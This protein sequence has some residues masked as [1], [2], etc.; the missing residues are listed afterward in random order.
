MKKRSKK[1]SVSNTASA[2]SIR[3]VADGMKQLE[4]KLAQ[5]RS[6]PRKRGAVDLQSVIEYVQSDAVRRITPFW[7]NA[8]LYVQREVLRE[9][10]TIQAQQQSIRL[11]RDS[12]VVFV[13]DAP[14]L[15]WG[16]P[17]RY[18]LYDARSNELY[19]QV[20]AAFPP[21]LVDT[22]E[23][24]QLYH[25]QVSI[26][27]S[28]LV[29]QV[30]PDRIPLFPLSRSQRYALLFSGASNNRHT[31]DLEFLFR[32]L[33][34][35]YGYDKNN[36]YVLNYDGTLNYNGDPQPASKWPGDNTN[37]RMH[38]DGE[39]TK[40]EFENA[41]D[42]LKSRLKGDD[43]LLIHTNNHGWYDDSGSFMSTYSGA[44]YYASELGDKLAT[45]PKFGCLIVMMEQ[46]ASGGFSQT[47]LD[48]SPAARTS[49]A[50]AC[51]PTVSSYG[52]SDF[53]FFAR[54][55]IA[56]M[57]GAD[58][59]GANLSSN[60]DT[61]QDGYISAQE[62]FNYANSVANASDS[63]NF[64]EKNDGGSCRLTATTG[65]RPWWMD[66]LLRA[67]D[68]FWR[69]PGP[70]PGPDVYRQIHEELMPRVENATRKFSKRAEALDREVSAQLKEIVSQVMR[71]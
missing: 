38:V 43:S 46:C 27:H 54:D 21:H 47:I 44:A 56:G 33:V 51:G 66:G 12:I 15:N 3:S 34:D 11:K 58:P 24:F 35:C 52:G 7:K 25:Q 17:C 40:A 59:Y 16:H 14:Q 8:N 37:Y 18:L 30:R 4:K 9:G 19:E 48:K 70:D 41:L 53:D 55:W 61:N 71:H 32:T 6:T 23:A 62:A 39:G 10:H 49:F 5:L 2:Q 13:D 69:I 50:A 60:A 45:L 68:P 31:N 26:D 20:Y 64:A 67:F 1:T 28:R 42:E 57:N 36:I 29:W 63:P 22:P 65:K